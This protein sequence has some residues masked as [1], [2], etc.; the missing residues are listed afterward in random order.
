MAP[1]DITSFIRDNLRLQPAPLVSELQLHLAH[2]RSGLSRLDLGETPFWAYLWP[3]GA[4]LARYLLDHPATVRGRSVLDIGTGG[5]V[6]AIAAVKAGAQRAIA[7]DVDPNAIAAAMLNASASK[8]EIEP[9]L[10]DLLGDL[11]GGDPPEPDLITIGDLFYDPDVARHLDA[12]V[13]RCLAAGKAV[14][15]GD[16][17]RGHLPRGRLELL[18]SY[19]VSDFGGGKTAG[20]RGGVYRF[21]R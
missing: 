2:S 6:A 14:L 19:D 1:H 12:F 20:Q 10:G 18:E 13:S 15:A 4:M 17:G 3:G 8:V 9:M 21:V 11:L 16:I 7:N 5:G